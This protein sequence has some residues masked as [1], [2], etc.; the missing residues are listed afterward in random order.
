VDD[1]WLVTSVNNEAVT[2]ENHKTGSIA[3]LGLDHIHSYLTDPARSSAA[4][5]HEFRRLHVQV[6]ISGNGVVSVTPPPPGGAVAT[7]IRSPLEAETARVAAD[8][9]GGLRA[10]PAARAAIR[11]LLVVGDSTEQQVFIALAPTGFASGEQNVLARLEAATQLVQRV[12]QVES[13]ETRI[14][15]YKGPY[16]ISP[17]TVR[18]STSCRG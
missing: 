13:R 15:G 14:F 5:K 18:R 7:T 11:H 4:Q 2:V 9:Y 17:T 3:A 8:K 10:W 6:E 12:E 16:A 1:D